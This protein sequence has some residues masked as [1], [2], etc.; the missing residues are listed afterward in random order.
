MLLARYV[1]LTFLLILTP[2]IWA[3]WIFPST[4]KF[5]GQWTNMFFKWTFFGPLVIFSMWLV[6][7]MGGEIQNGHVAILKEVSYNSPS[8]AG[9]G[10]SDF[11]GNLL[12][13]IMSPF[14]NGIVLVGLMVGGL[15]MANKLGIA[16]AKAGMAGIDKV[17]NSV[18]GYATR[19]IGRGVR[20]VRENV[21][22]R[23]RSAG[24]KYDPATGQ[25]TTRLQRL[26][27]K[28]QTIPG[29]RHVPGMK[30]IGS[31]IARQ[32]AVTQKQAPEE[33]EKYR[34]E[35]L[36]SL[37]DEAILVRAKSTTA[38]I[39]QKEAAALGQELARRNLTDKLG[40]SSAGL[41]DKYIAVAEKMGTAQSIYIN[42]PDLVQAREKSPGVMETRA[43]AMARVV[44]K[45]KV[46]DITNLDPN[47]LVLKS[48]TLSYLVAASWSYKL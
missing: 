44:K 33:V 2:L 4:E 30:T 21:S 28:L 32:G 3:A 35:N 7:T 36:D 17:R 26:G 24:T 48:V 39:N 10:I 45:M 1:I 19:K 27:S 34:K 11:F 47:T 9:A 14:L 31:N 8:G 15:M 41:M 40:P 23:V 16:G 18:Q 6:I 12:S 13:G 25:T 37:T 43:E 22:S 42:R 5:V 29:V 38:F 20:G 46:G